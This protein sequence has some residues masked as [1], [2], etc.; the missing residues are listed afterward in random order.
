MRRDFIDL[1]HALLLYSHDG[2]QEYLQI[3][4]KKNEKDALTIIRPDVARGL[5]GE[6]NVR[7]NFNGDHAIEDVNADGDRVAPVILKCI[8]M[9][10][11]SH[12]DKDRNASS[13]D[14]I[15]MAVK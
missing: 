14:N 13:D 9:Q 12:I 1:F 2:R 11:I 6:L 3:S 15:Q 5:H 4:K 7:I 8:I 10:N